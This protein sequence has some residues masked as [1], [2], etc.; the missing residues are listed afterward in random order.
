[1]TNS[2]ENFHIH[3]TL[4]IVPFKVIIEVIDISVFDFVSQG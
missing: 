1:M 4:T 3:L 2:D